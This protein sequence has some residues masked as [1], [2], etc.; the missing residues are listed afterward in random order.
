MDTSDLHLTA[1]PSVVWPTNYT[2][3]SQSLAPAA[4]AAYA[5]G[6]EKP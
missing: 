5:F 2:H 6:E 3:S 4:K 1:G